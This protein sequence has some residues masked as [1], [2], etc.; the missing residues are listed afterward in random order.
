VQATSPLVHVPAAAGAA[1]DAA[2]LAAPV[3][4]AGEAAEV[5]K[6]VATWVAVGDA[7]T[8]A[9][10][11]PGAK[12]PPDLLAAG[13]E[14]A[15][16]EATGAEATGA[17]AAGVAAPTPV[18][19]PLFPAEDAATGA[20][21]LP[22]GAAL[23]PEEEPAGV[24]DPDPQPVPAGALSGLLRVASKVTYLPGSGKSVLNCSVVLHWLTLA[25]LATNILGRELI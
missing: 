18:Y 24:P 20:T 21:E 16:A 5:T 4:A 12:T 13:A 7:A 25:R 14:A 17:E 11:A 22:A 8:G 1:G 10:L 3:E 23:L 2:G 9:E 6:V 15:G 19:C